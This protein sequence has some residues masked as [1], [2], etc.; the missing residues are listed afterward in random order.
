MDVLVS[1]IVPVL[2]DSA[3]A[4][5]LLASLPADSR[6]E[7]IVVDGGEDPQLER[8]AESEP[9]VRL[10]RSQPGRA[11]QMNAGSALARGAWLLFLHADSTLPD[12]WVELFARLSPATRGGWFQFALDDPAWQARVIERGVAW[13]VRW[14]RLPYG[15]QGLFVRRDVFVGLRGYR[16]MPLMEDVEFAGR[17]IASGPM[18]ELPVRLETSAR[19]WRQHGWFRRSATNVFLLTLY[20]AGVSPTRLARLYR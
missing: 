17:L 11:V 10:I 15:D 12:H 2:N 14:L 5:R 16:D 8:L 1:V 18:V 9:R 19:R 6:V 4:A 3:A 20:F 7:A 13:R